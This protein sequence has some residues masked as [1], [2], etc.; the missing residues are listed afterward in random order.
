VVKNPQ[1]LKRINPEYM[2]QHCSAKGK[3]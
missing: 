2:G 1:T 3:Y